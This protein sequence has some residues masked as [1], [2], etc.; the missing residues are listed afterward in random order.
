MQRSKSD[1]GTTSTISAKDRYPIVRKRNN[2]ENE[3]PLSASKKKPLSPIIENSPISE[4]YFSPKSISQDNREPLPKVA[5]VPPPRKRQSSSPPAGNIGYTSQE[6]LDLVPGKP[7]ETVAVNKKGLAHQDMHSSQQPA[8]KIP[9][10]KG[11][12]VD[13]IIKRLTMDRFSPPPAQLNGTTAFSY[14]RPNDQKI[15]YAQVVCDNSDGKSKQTIPSSSTPTTTGLSSHHQSYRNVAG[16]A[17]EITNNNQT[18]YRNVPYHERSYSPVQHL[19]AFRRSLSPTYRRPNSDEDEGLGFDVVQPSTTH[20][21]RDE[22]LIVPIIRDYRSQSSGPMDHSYRGKADGTE[23]PFPE[24]NE[25]SARRKQ[26]ELRMCSRRIGSAEHIPNKFKNNNNN[27]VYD[28]Y[29]N[30][31]VDGHAENVRRYQRSRSSELLR[32]EHD[33]SDRPQIYPRYVVQKYSP[34]RTMSGRTE[35]ERNYRDHKT[36]RRSPPGKIT[37]IDLGYIDDYQHQHHHHHHNQERDIYHVGRDIE[38]RSLDSQF[39]VLNRSSPEV[40]VGYPNRYEQQQP[41][42]S[43]DTLKREKKQ[44]RSFDKGDSGIENDYRKDSFNE[45]I[46]NR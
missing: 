25:L 5:V 40:I 2:S 4:P 42:E 28:Q 37:E 24:F 14:I 39:S 9:L 33:E 18:L 45:D 16:D 22:P 6:D 34:E 27:N 41:P 20:Y 15:I 38:P 35:E 1:V 21:H 3:E 31:G 12:T 36:Y 10:T 7:A 19:P 44:Q 11:V 8:E 13:G 23:E 17:S 26:L 32:S 43:F 29:H 46:G 30:D